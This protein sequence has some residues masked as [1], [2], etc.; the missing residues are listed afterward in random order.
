VLEVFVLR[1]FWYCVKVQGTEEIVEGGGGR[2]GRGGG[3][4]QEEAAEA[5]FKSREY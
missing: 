1:W 4:S 5:D 2:G 3:E